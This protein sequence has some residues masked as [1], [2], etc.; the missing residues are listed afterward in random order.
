M[1]SGDFPVVPARPPRPGTTTAL[2]HP[3][4]AGGTYF[5]QTRAVA[6]LSQFI[7]LMSLCAVGLPGC[8]DAPPEYSVPERLPPI[9]DEASAAPPM[10]TLYESKLQTPTDLRIPFRSDTSE[11][12]LQAAFIV[13]ADSGHEVTLFIDK[14]GP[15]DTQFECK[16]N[17]PVDPGCHTITV[18]A[19][20]VRNF[21][22]NTTV[23]DPSL[24]TEATWFA[25]Y[26]SVM[27]TVDCFKFSADVP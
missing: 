5:G 11:E 20:Y 24:A 18:R 12:E 13:D 7:A 23:K 14:A 8:F 19:S 4:R 6:C 26:G 9:L 22:D 16:A 1:Q 21:G 10:N 3:D 15:G 27:P 25:L 2:S 17:W